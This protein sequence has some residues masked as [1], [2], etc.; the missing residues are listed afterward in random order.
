MILLMV[1]DIEVVIKKLFP[2][3]FIQLVISSNYVLN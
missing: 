1:S 2:E 3:L